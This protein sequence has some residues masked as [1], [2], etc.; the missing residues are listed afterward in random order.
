M[1][2]ISQ[3]IKGNELMLFKDNK[4]LACATNHTFNI[5]VNTA[6]VAHKDTGMWQTSIVTGYAWEVSSD[7]LMV[8]AEYKKLFKELIAGNPVELDFAIADN[9]NVNGIEAIVGDAWTPGT[10]LKLTGKA[11]IT[12]LNINSP[13]GDNATYSITLKGYGPLTLS[14]GA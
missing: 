12:A 6:D 1:G 5:T 9:F 10:E 4:S 2:Q 7:N 3:T 11:V 13:A 14:E 8:V